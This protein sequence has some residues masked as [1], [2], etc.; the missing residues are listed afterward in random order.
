MFHNIRWTTQKITKRLELLETLVYKRR[1]P[2]PAFKYLQLELADSSPPITLDDLTDDWK[3]IPWGS[4]WGG[5]NINF[6]LRTQ[7]DIPQDWTTDPIMLLLPIGISGDFS[8]PE[9]LVYVDSAPIAACDRHHQVMF[10]PTGITKEPH[11]ELALHGWTGIMRSEAQGW[12]GTMGKEAHTKIRMH[13]CALAQIDPQTNEFVITARVALGVVQR[14][15]QHE[16][17][18]TL[19]L[20]AL[21]DAFIALDTREPLSKNFYDSVQPALEILRDGIAQAGPPMNVEITAV[22]HAHIDVA[23]LWTLAQTRQKA[24]RT[25]YNVLQLMQRFPD[26]RFVQSQPQLYDFIREDDSELFNAIKERVKAKQWELIGGMWVEPDCNLSGGEALVRQ[27]ILGRHFFHQ[28]FGKD[29]DSPV[30]WLP[31][32]FGYAWNL[33]QLI[34]EAGLEYFFTIKLGWNQYNR[35]PYDS[36]WWQ[37]LDGTKVLTHFSTTHETGSVMAS[38]YNA[39]ATPDEVHNTW[40]NFQQKD[41]G[42]PGTTPPL[43]MVYGYGDGGGGPTQEM[44]EN[45]QEMQSFP[46]TPQTQ[47]G[48]VEA[49]FRKLES[50][51]GDKLPSWNGE[52]YLEYHR[53]TYT[54]QARSKRANRKSE[55]LLHDAEFLACIASILDPGYQYPHQELHQAWQL[56]CL[57]Q[58]HDILPGTSISE[59]YAE[60]L[61]QYAEIK[62]LGNSIQKDSLAILSNTTS[63]NLAIINPTSFARDDLALLPYDNKDEELSFEHPDGSSVNVQWTQEGYLIDA[64]SL[65]PYSITPLTHTDPRKHD[66]D[67]GRALTVTRS[68]LENDFLRVE[69]NQA[70]DIER[71]YDKEMQR[72]VLAPNAIANQ[73]QIFEDRPRTPDAWEIEIYYDDRVWYANSAESIKVVES[74]PLR[75]TLE[76]RR[77]V[78]NSDLEQR[79]S[80]AHNSRRLDFDTTIQWREKHTLLKTAFPVNVLAPKA[81]HEIQWGNVERPTHRNTSWDW[82]RFETCAHKWVDL[83]EGGYGVSLLNDC[84]YGHDI[85]GNVIRLSLLRSP[86]YPDPNADQGEHHFIYSLLPHPGSWDDLTVREAYALNNPLI[87]Y[88]SAS[89][90][91]ETNSASANSLG[92]SKSLSFFQIDQPNVIIET[93]KRAEDGQGIIVRLYEYQRNRGECTLR[94]GFPINKAWR[95]NLLEEN[96]EQLEITENSVTLAISPYKVIT[97][98][99]LPAQTKD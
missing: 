42:K 98:R 2:L 95:T 51:V 29:S 78:Q 58:F 50:E 92:Y 21:D 26:F 64:G 31:D 35:L 57:N 61:H 65:P 20:N 9:A 97:L 77:K 53:G 37:G 90:K 44:V 80:L 25:F 94:L 40:R 67:Q 55:F 46:A 73:F 33:P 24:Q 88:D 6:V 91:G 45:I 68:L 27:L 85:Q 69:L 8:H 18:R 11:H 43:F 79:I 82:A 59:V 47:F 23:W 70:G 76:I 12:T 60:S 62:A 14:L 38:T 49:F 13:E 16:P 71:I 81:T 83:S 30:L 15:G 5:P 66:Q 86:S 28:H 39:K 99:L 1:H 10:L 19:L 93:I 32:V 87:V 63:G 4:Y 52:L 84:K 89:L 22:G 56:V 7:F 48:T 54:T 96:Q 41:L 34:K 3:T 74:G 36:F 72:E 17:A 75:A